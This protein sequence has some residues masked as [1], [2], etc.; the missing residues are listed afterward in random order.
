ME[1]GVRL[2]DGGLEPSA[3]F[4]DDGLELGERGEVPV[5]DRLV[6]QGPEMLGRLQLRAVG[7]QEHQADPLGDGQALRSVP[8][9]VV[10]HEDD[11][12]FSAGAG[13]PREAVFRAKLASSASKKGLERPLQRYQ[14]VSPLVG[15]TKATTCSHS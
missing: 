9:G 10:Q 2:E 6:D 3:A 11:V 14:T 12:A 15:C 5:D 1:V 13:L 4:G 7:R 8:A